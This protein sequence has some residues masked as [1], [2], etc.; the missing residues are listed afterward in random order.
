MK[1]P[2][3]PLAA[4]LSD[5]LP[6]IDFAVLQNGFARHGRDYVFVI[7]ATMCP[8]PG[9]YELI[10]THVVQLNYETRV[11][12]DVWPRSWDDVFLDYSEWEASG[13]PPGYVWGSDWS[14][15][16]PG[17]EAP[18]NVP[19]ALDWSRRLGKQMHGMSLET[20]RFHIS[21]IFHD[22]YA[23]AL[24]DDTSTLSQVLIPLK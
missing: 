6:E 1:A 16:Y 7:Q 15:A 9:T 8:K 11:R 22:V 17:I 14:L 23:R 10:F 18:E 21:M 24:S 19:E 3:N 13:E 2:S 12:D 20:D 5:W 4:H